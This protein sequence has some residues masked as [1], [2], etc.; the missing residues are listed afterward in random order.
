MVRLETSKRAAQ[1][2]V[3]SNN[4]QQQHNSEGKVEKNRSKL[5]GRQLKEPTQ[6]GQAGQS[7]WFCQ[8]QTNTDTQPADTTSTAQES[9]HP[10]A[11]PTRKHPSRH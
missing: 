11:M 7:Q 4:E 9:T 6:G 8:K 3:A 5:A 1:D 10:T 2:Y